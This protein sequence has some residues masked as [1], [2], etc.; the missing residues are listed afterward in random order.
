MSEQRTA[1]LRENRLP[2][3]ERARVSLYLDPA[4]YRQV[5]KLAA[6]RDC[7]PHTLLEEGVELVLL[8][9]GVSPRRTGL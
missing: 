9:Y 3:K 5:K 8:K 7:R 6:E 4:M 1:P 2:A